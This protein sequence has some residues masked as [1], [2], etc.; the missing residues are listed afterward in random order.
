MTH[1][2]RSSALRAHE[3]PNQSENKEV[4]GEQEE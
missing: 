2:N 3:P 1:I 4:L